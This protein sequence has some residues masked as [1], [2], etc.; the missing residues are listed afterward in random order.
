MAS[1]SGP[2]YFSFL[3]PA[4]H[5]CFLKRWHRTSCHSFIRQSTHL[6]ARFSGIR[7]SFQGLRVWTCQRPSVLAAMYFVYDF[8]RH[9]SMIN[10]TNINVLRNF[11]STF[12][13]TY[14][15]RFFN[16]EIT[17]CY[18]ATS[19]EFSRIK[20]IYKSNQTVRTSASCVIFSQSSIIRTTYD[21]STLNCNS[22]CETVSL[23]FPKVKTP[24]LQDI[25][26][27]TNRIEL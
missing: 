9:V 20:V 6:S 19:L 13:Y 23:G 24:I 7:L 8:I 1:I 14:D 12:Y 25:K 2:P 16:I 11:P 15:L 3:P 27:F 18:E 5:S 21:S 26:L 10:C 17:T 4:S 22:S